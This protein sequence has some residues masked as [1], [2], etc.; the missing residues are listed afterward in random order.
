M[1]EHTLHHVPQLT[2]WWN[3]HFILSHNQSHSSQHQD[4]VS[5]LA[6]YA[7][8]ASMVIWGQASWWNPP[9]I[10]GYMRAS[11]MVEPTLHLW[12]YE[13]KHHGGTHPS[14]MV[15]WGQASWWN[16]HF[17]YGYM[18]ASIMVEPTVIWGQASWWNPH[19]I[20]SLCRA[21]F[22]LQWCTTLLYKIQL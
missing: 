8:S 11:I 12:L 4:G 20:S 18:R 14:S 10:Y 2:T 17:I 7:Q 19:F 13:G 3:M 16:P 21:L 1:T 6:F 15:I 9:F 22:S 5:N